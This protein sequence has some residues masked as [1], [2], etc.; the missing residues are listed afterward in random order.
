MAIL[1]IARQY[2]S[3][4]KEIGRKAADLLNYAY[5]DRTQIF[6]EMK[7][8]G[9]DWEKEAKYFDENQPSIWERY[10]WSYRGFV[11]LNQSHI[12]NYALRNRVVIM[13]RGGNF[14]TKDVPYALRIRLT[15]PIDKRIENVMQWNDINN[16]ENA[17]L[18]IEKVDREMAGAVYS[19]YGSTWD[20]PENYD[21]VFDAGL[22]TQDE[23][24]NII[25]G[26]IEKKDKF[27]TDKARDIL[28]LR[29]LAAKIKAAIAI[30]PDLFVST[31]DVKLKE[32]GLV[33]YGLIVTGAIYNQTDKGKIEETVKGLSGDV[34]VEFVFHKRM[35]P[36]F[37]ALQFK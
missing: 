34:P 31:L 37:G 21:L 5:I 14:L 24:V 20:D 2:G 33:E 27:Y 22:Q 12:L 7:K 32:E 18:L 26:E 13:G 4:G 10:K 3:G 23:I 8:A 29:V 25:K 6:Q 16:T 30:N 11:A 1:T 36:R 15:A 28:E 19:I 17:R 35:Y 9:I